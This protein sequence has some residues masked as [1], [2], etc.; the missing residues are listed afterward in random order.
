MG[1]TEL[2]LFVCACAGEEKLSCRRLRFSHLATAGLLSHYIDFD[3]EIPLESPLSTIIDK[4]GFTTF[5]QPP[6]AATGR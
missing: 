5:P 4:F 1:L 2:L 3:E 6:R